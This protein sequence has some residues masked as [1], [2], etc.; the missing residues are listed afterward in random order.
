MTDQTRTPAGE[1]AKATTL[2]QPTKTVETEDTTMTEP[3]AAAPEPKVAASETRSHPTTQAS[4][5]P[6]T[7]A[8]GTSRPPRSPAAGPASCWSTKRRSTSCRRYATGWAN[9]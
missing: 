8:G 5:A 1:A 6:D 7:E 4:P 9:R 3:K 2:D